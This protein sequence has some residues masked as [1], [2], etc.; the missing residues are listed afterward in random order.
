M[1]IPVISGCVDD[2]LGGV[3][4]FLMNGAM[5]EAGYLFKYKTNV[6]ELE[7]NLVKLEGVL[8]RVQ[9]GVEEDRRNAK[10]VYEDVSKWLENAGKMKNEL[11]A[12][13]GDGTQKRAQGVC[14]KLPFPNLYYRFKL[15]REA[16]KKSAA[17]SELITDG[18]PFKKSD[19]LVAHLPLPV[20]GSASIS[21]ADHK[22]QSFESREKVLKEIVAALK[23]DTVPIVGIYGMPGVGKTTMMEQVR[24]QLVGEKCFEEVAL[25]VVS[26]TLDVKSIQRQLANDLGLT[27][28]AKKEDEQERAWLLKR[29]LN[30]GKKVLLILD[31]VWSKLRLTDIGIDFGD[32]KSCKI[33]MTS[34]EKRVCDDNNCRPF[35]IELL[36]EVEAWCLFKQHAGDCIEKHE[37]RPSA[38]KA[39]K[40]CGELPLVIRAIGEA[41]KGGNLFEWKD[42]LE[43]FKN[44]SPQKIANVDDQVYKTLE[45]SFNLLKSQ[46]TKVCL[47]LCS[48]L[49]EDAEIS[50]DYLTALVKAMGYLPDMD[51]LWKARNRVLSLVK[52][53]KSSCLL[54]E[55]RYENTVKM[56]DA[57][58][59]VAV[60]IA[61]KELN[62]GI[63][64]KSGITE[65]PMVDE[66]CQRYGAISL[67][68]HLIL[69]FPRILECPQLQTFSLINYGF[70]SI[71]VPNTFF[72]RLEKL[73][74]LAMSNVS[75]SSALLSLPNP[76]NLRMLCLEGCKLE[77]VTILKGLPKLEVLILRDDTIQELP[78]EFRQLKNLL[79][80]DLRG[81]Y[82]L[83]VIEPGVLSSL[84][85]LEELYLPRS[86]TWDAKVTTNE[87]T[88]TSILDELRSLIG[89]TT[90]ETHIPDIMTFPDYEFCKKLVRYDISVG[91]FES[92]SVESRTISTNSDAYIDL[93]GGIKVLV[94]GAE[95]LNFCASHASYLNFHDSEGSKRLHVYYFKGVEHLLDYRQLP[96]GSFSV[97]KMLLVSS[98]G[99]KYLFNVSVARGLKQLQRLDIRNCHA[100]EAIVRNECNGDEE[101]IKDPVI[102]HKLKYFGLNGMK[103]LTS[104]YSEIRKTRGNPN[105]N[106]N[107]AQSLFD[108]KL[109]NLE[110]LRIQYC[111]AVTSEVVCASP[112]EPF[113]AEVTPQLAKLRNLRLLSL[114]NLKQTA[115]NSSDFHDTFYSKLTDLCIMNCDSL[116]NIFSPSVARNLK[117]LERLEIQS[118]KEILEVIAT[119]GQDQQ[120]TIDEIIF[121]QL[122]YLRLKNMP[123]LSNFWNCGCQEQHDE[124]K[125]E[126]DLC[127]PQ[128][129]FSNKLQN[130]EEITI[131]HCAAMT[132]EV[133]CST[134]K[135]PFQ[136]EV[137]PQLGK[138][139]NLRLLNLPNLKQTALNSNDFHDTFYPK[140]TELC[141]LNCG[142]LRN[143][144]SPSVARNLKHLNIL[145]IR[146]S[147]EIE[148]IIATAGQGQE[149]TIDEIIFPQLTYLELQNVPKLSNFWNYGCQEQH[150]EIKVES[151]LCQ[152][153][154]LFGQK[155]T[156]F[157]TQRTLN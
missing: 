2:V 4:S 150:E 138:L 36:N 47:F 116:K 20:E 86:Y 70:G 93:K 96:S 77:D 143:V 44:F 129:L 51:S 40:E 52:V 61:P 18:K 11:E 156:I 45:L 23:D 120:E 151:D 92:I 140:L 64:V 10:D 26:A 16:S 15:G 113:Q 119:S 101:E 153:Q 102:F 56:H 118:S 1:S 76:K 155:W 94:E 53:L 146:Y 123:K 65:W 54:L 14:F 139:R 63:L 88:S 97:L 122:T 28:L 137:T 85:Y 149:E 22:Y 35:K 19:H 74:V 12:F 130:L 103:S 17:V 58:R 105:P 107:P 141:I 3:R 152:P 69:E 81:C 75:I 72:D 41:L 13:L 33:L 89:V 50:I 21:T 73:N 39:L 90:L 5:R 30:N 60:S 31:D 112:K 37:I 124:I 134:S 135:E 67:R 32:A 110:E 79:V 55:G 8:S 42:A 57:V 99:F 78:L 126:S 115:L 82:R 38:Q 109:Q 147:E 68:F 111:A 114:P 127:Q 9:D 84:S 87:I 157:V 83:R 66:T 29:R 100:M 25:A 145:K 27:D 148:E 46:E 48:I 62:Y 136:V 7:K 24:S 95:V 125:M 59:D 144:F 106:P 132:S 98:G 142:S 91:N 133:A 108:E 128:P 154:P 117:H 80:L 104:F 43:Q 71:Q 49:G 131:Q 121:S 34:R 6:T